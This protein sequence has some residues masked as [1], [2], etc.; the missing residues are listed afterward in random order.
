MNH[1]TTMFHYE[2]IYMRHYGP[3]KAFWPMMLYVLATCKMCVNEIQRKR[4]ARA[5]FCSETAL[6][7]TRLV[8]KLSVCKS[9]NSFQIILKW[10]S[11]NSCLKYPFRVDKDLHRGNQRHH[12]YF[13]LLSPFSATVHH[14]HP[15]CDK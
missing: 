1:S 10:C 14:V 12:F 2:I 15:L 7:S 3:K 8:N 11:P 5:G 9:K 6:K 13:G 4:S